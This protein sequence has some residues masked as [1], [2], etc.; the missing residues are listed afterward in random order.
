VLIQAIGDLLPAALAVAL[1]PIPIIA[2]VLV[3]GTPH[4]RSVS[5]TFALGSVVGLAAVSTLVVLLAGGASDR[6][7]DTATGVNWL[8]VAI[9]V[10][11]LVMAARQWAKRPRPGQRSEEPKWMAQIDTLTPSRAWVLGLAL[12][13]ANPKNLALTL[14][15]AASIAQAGLDRA[16][17][18]VAVAVF[19]VVASLTVAG[20]VLYYLIT[21]NRAERHLAVVKEFMADHNSVIIMMVV[22]LLLGA[23]LLGDGLGGIWR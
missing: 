1:S 15:A 17:T 4:A 22:L 9:G 11:F 12:S 13:A 14:A 18:A 21:P 23:K 10:L 20:S 16:D 8:K 7:S 3:L 2:I 6:A 19:V 5:P